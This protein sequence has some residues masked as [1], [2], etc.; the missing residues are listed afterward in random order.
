MKRNVL[1]LLFLSLMQSQIISAQ[2]AK[3][4]W[5]AGNTTF[6]FTY[7][8]NTY[9]AGDYHDGQIITNVYNV[10]PGGY[11]TTSQPW[12]AIR[13]LVTSVVIEPNFSGFCPYSLAY[14]FS[15]FSNLTTTTGLDNNINT[16]NLTNIRDAFSGCSKLTSLEMLR[17]WNVSNV[18]DMSRLFYSCTGLTSLEPLKGWDISNVTNLSYAFRGCSG[19]SSLEP[20]KDWNTSNVSNMS[21][22]FCQCQGITS[23]EP[24][25]D[26]DVS[27]VTQID[28]IFENLRNIPSLEP[29]KDWDIS[30]VTNM[31]GAFRSCTGLTSLE[32]LTNWNTQNVQNMSNVF[33]GCNNLTSLESLKDWNTSSATDFAGIFQGCSRLTSLDGIKDWNTAN[34][35]KMNYAF[36]TCR[37]LTSLEPLKDWN[38]SSV[39]E[40]KHTFE[41]C[42][43]L[44]SLDGIKDWNTANVTSI[45]YA[46]SSCT[47][48]TSLDGIK[49]WDTSNVTNMF[50][51]FRLCNNLT[52]VHLSGWDS[53][54]TTNMASLFE[55]CAKLR[56]I[57]FG[58]HFNMNKVSNANN[59]FRNCNML[60]YIDFYNISYAT[61]GTGL[62]T[63]LN[64]VQ[65]NS[66]TFSG[67]PETT[68]IYL[69][70]R[71]GVVDNVTNVVFSYN[72]NENDL[73]CPNYYSIDK[74][75]IE[76]P[77]NFKTNEAV[78]SR[79]M[80]NKEYGSV[81]LPYAFTS[82]SDIQTYSLSEQNGDMTKLKFTDVQT[83]PAHT[84]F[85]FKRLNNAEFLM[86]DDS[87]NFGITVHATRS[88]NA[89]E[90]TWSQPGPI[91][92]YGSPYEGSTGLSNW[93]TKGYYVKETVTDYDGMYFIQNSEFKRATGNLNLVDHRVLFYPT[94]VTG[95]SKF[96]TLSF[97]DDEV[98]TAIEAA[99]T[100]QALRQA[101]GIYDTT[102]RRQTTAHRGLNIVRMSDGT[103]RKVLV[104]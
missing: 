49:D 3:A 89:A 41:S 31:A 33:F 94:D 86:K 66:G 40:M 47:G 5:C 70:K 96:F 71:N 29:L 79:T 25:K 6:Y 32:P 63:P 50:A 54:N 38:T 77:R 68:V 88:T 2:T 15:N 19:V 58:E 84:P 67:V 65:R 80:G 42:I 14:W 53:G 52:L 102:G 64:T 4:L 85:A 28:C 45:E 82:N 95:A 27:N 9:A 92:A 78:Y 90:E 13:E 21:N 93:K 57:I 69:P 60:R 74:V 7:D 73:R 59:M 24:L 75:D 104:K 18:S 17:N 48:L 8:T 44:T 11:T 56:G 101:A 46:F 51:T 55:S 1:L 26:W 22:T 81:V 87:G 97:S 30:N 10:A 23:L 20:L 35:K 100:E 16:S 91:T 62:E 99:E 37:M 12:R 34:V 76:F 98:V 72:G 83:V 61:S 43:N 36:S 39:I 103:V